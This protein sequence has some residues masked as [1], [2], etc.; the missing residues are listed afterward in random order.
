MTDL[1]RN[2]L[3]DTN[4][5]QKRRK[6]SQSLDEKLI[7]VEGGKGGR[8]NNGTERFIWRKK[9]EAL[10][11]Q[12]VHLTERDLERQAEEA[13]L[14]LENEKRA[15]EKRDRE[16]AIREADKRR[17]TQAKMEVDNRDLEDKEEEFNVRQYYLGQA[18]RLREGRGN[19]V[20]RIAQNLRCDLKDVGRD[21]A[22]P[23]GVIDNLLETD[24]VQQ[25]LQQVRNETEYLQW[26]DEAF[27]SPAFNEIVR[28]DWWKMVEAVLEEN[29]TRGGDSIHTSVKT[30]VDAVIKGKSN[31]ELRVLHKQVKETIEN[32][33]GDPDFWI[34]VE[35][36][37]SV[38]LARNRLTLLNNLLREEKQSIVAGE[39]ESG[40][41]ERPNDEALMKGERAKG[42][43]QNEELFSDEI[44]VDGKSGAADERSSKPNSRK[45]K[46][47]NRVYTGYEWNKYNRTHYDHDNPP[48]K[49]VQGYK[50]NVF[51]PDLIDK[52]VAPTFSIKKTEN[53]EVAILRFT[54]GPPYDDIAFKIVN[55]EWEHSH[56]R[57]FRCS[58]ERGILHLWFNFKRYRY[59]R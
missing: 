39:K 25:L 22:G 6:V 41:E 11:K 19:L 43:G 38:T 42:L 17:E 2:P 48:P 57:G 34:A 9:H 32:D 5:G 49:T 51:Y 55:R 14:E 7:G 54:A 29:I 4:A 44:R 59:R 53:P 46:Y 50:F 8:G 18:I 36:K 21:E 3:L 40:R 31:R 56:R 58:F 1:K 28:K 37:I 45:P 47:H 30:K 15:R 33:E 26:F 23:L 16:R 24:D 27:D 35:K 52:T 13:R 10:A 12:G 20:D